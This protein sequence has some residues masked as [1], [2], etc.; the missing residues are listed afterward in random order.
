M[1]SICAVASHVHVEALMDRLKVAPHMCCQWLPSCVAGDRTWRQGAAL[2]TLVCSLR[3]PAVV[4]ALLTAM[5]V[6]P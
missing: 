6:V 1:A 2:Q 4:E 3:L 5:T